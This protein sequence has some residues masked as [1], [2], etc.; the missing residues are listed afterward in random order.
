MYCK[1]S[2]ETA[3]T[4]LVGA[5]LRRCA[6]FAAHLDHGTNSLP[7]T[8]KKTPPQLM[9]TA[10]DNQA[11]IWRYLPLGNLSSHGVSKLKSVLFWYMLIVDYCL[12]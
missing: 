2:E 6:P 10:E 4:S 5:V 9:A 8:A 3:L 12:L 11:S 1:I 7:G